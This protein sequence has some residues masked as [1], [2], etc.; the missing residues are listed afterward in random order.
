M[1]KRSY[2]PSDVVG[3]LLIFVRTENKSQLVR[4]IF[5]ALFIAIQ[6]FLGVVLPKI[7]IGTIERYGKDAT[8]PMAKVMAIYF[9]IAGFIAFM[10]AYLSRVTDSENI[11]LRMHYLALLSKK[12]QNMD[13]KYVED[14]T[15]REKNERAMQ[16]GSSSGNGIELLL[17]LIYK[18]PAYLLT[19]IAMA[20]VAFTLSPIVLVMT[21]L[22]CVTLMWVS[23]KTHDYEYSLKEEKSKAQ[24]RISYFNKTTHDFS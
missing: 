6:P 19:L 13:Y 10:S 3:R 17:N 5:A 21:V 22:H 4:M 9:V 2:K 24:R 7:A 20:V 23:V 12:I 18:A 16:A 8:L 1:E 11:R 15:F 14:A